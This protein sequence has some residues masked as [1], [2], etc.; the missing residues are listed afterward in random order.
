MIWSCHPLLL[1]FQ[2][3]RMKQSKLEE[4]PFL[5]TLILVCS[6]FTFTFFSL[7]NIL[8]FFSQIFQ[9]LKIF[10][11]RK[12]GVHEHRT[13]ERGKSAIMLNAFPPFL[14]LF[15]PRSLCFFSLFLLHFLCFFQKF[16]YNRSPSLSHTPPP[17]SFLSLT[18][19]VYITRIFR[20][21]RPLLGCGQ[22]PHCPIF[23]YSLILRLYSP[24][25]PPP[26]S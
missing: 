2:K 7:I 8:K 26:Y 20:V 24:S 1:V 22:S 11:I 13:K 14:S 5:S 16:S 17:C 18:H 4:Q 19:N 9:V 10:E 23:F 15:L 6:R 21:H 25:L 12:R 3:H